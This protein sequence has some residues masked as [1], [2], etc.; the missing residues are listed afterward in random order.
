MFVTPLPQTKRPRKLLPSDPPDSAPPRQPYTN[1]H[2]RVE[3]WPLC[4]N[5]AD[6][7]YKYPTF[8]LVSACFHSRCTSLCV[9]LPSSSFSPS[10]PPRRPRPPVAR[11]PS[12]GRPWTKRLLR[13]GLR[14]RGALC[15]WGGTVPGGSPQRGAGWGGVRPTV[16]FL[17]RGGGCWRSEGAGRVWVGWSAAE[18]CRINRS[19]TIS[20]ASRQSFQKKAPCFSRSGHL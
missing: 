13:R 17:R 3:N 16:L 19:G 20:S 10:S 18:P 1:T 2:S 4:F 14:L 7:K 12:P 9:P 6:I 11:L 5:E 8:L 15:H